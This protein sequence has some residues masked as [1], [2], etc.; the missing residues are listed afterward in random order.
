MFLPACT[1]GGKHVRCLG[2]PQKKTFLIGLWIVSIPCYLSASELTKVLPVRADWTDP[3]CQQL[4]TDQDGPFVLLNDGSILTVEGNSA[5]FSSDDGQ[6]WT[7]SGPLLEDRDPQIHREWRVL[8]QTNLGAIVLVF[9][10]ISSRKWSWDKKT[11]EPATDVFT[12][13]WSLRTLDEGKTWVDPRLLSSHYCGAI[14]DITQTQSGRIVVPVMRIL[15]NPGRHAFVTYISDDQGQSWSSSNI[16]DLGG[17]GHHDGAIE[18]TLVELRD[19]R[20][21]ALIRTNLDRFWEAFSHDQG[22]SWRVIQPSKIDSSSAPGYMTRLTSGRLVLAWNRLYPK[23]M[24]AKEWNSR[25]GSRRSFP[26][27]RVPGSS[28]REELSIAFSDD[29][30]KTWSNPQVIARQS[31]GWLSYPYIFERHTGEL[32]LTTHYAGTSKG[33]NKKVIAGVRLKLIESDFVKQ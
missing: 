21:W 9:M 1:L 19:G 33:A 23:G 12:E 32:W 29:D 18:P 2:L 17:H 20:L 14:V 16:I 6:T 30:G 22:L 5:H 24:S 15:R 10:D 8:Q 13:V 31:E 4:P 26:Y 11:N 25:P 27:S 7:Q 28:Q 3:R